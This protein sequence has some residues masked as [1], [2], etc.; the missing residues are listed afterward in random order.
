MAADPVVKMPPLNNTFGPILFKYCPYS[1]DTMNTTNSKMPNTSPYSVALHPFLSACIAIN[2][3]HKKKH[4]IFSN[5]FV[6][7]AKRM[8]CKKTWDTYA[9]FVYLQLIL[10]EKFTDMSKS[11]KIEDFRVYE[12]N[13]KMIYFINWMKKIFSM[14]FA[15]ILIMLLRYE[16]AA[17]ATESSLLTINSYVVRP[18]YYIIWPMIT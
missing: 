7:L 16:W 4:W 13:N 8:L 3:S 18:P 9:P 12:I 17:M 11:M 15:S 14:W 6:Q 2:K 5:E 10:I 1:G